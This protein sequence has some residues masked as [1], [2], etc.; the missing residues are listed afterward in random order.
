MLIGDNRS[1]DAKL[2]FVDTTPATPACYFPA[3]ISLWLATAKTRSVPRADRE[4]AHLM[5]SQV[6]SLSLLLSHLA[7]ND[8]RS[9]GGVHIPD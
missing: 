5:E 9:L 3:P 7:Y 8:P 4:P 1:N 6:L 2:L